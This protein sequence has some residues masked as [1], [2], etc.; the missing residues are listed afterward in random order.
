MLI[1]TAKLVTSSSVEHLLSSPLKNGEI[2]YIVKEIYFRD[3]T[4]KCQNAGKIVFVGI[5]QNA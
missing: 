4:I 3:V 5:T 2:F 1:K